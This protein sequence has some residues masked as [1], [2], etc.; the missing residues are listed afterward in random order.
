MNTHHQH[1]VE[2]QISKLRPTQMTVGRAEVEAK[3]REWQALGRKARERLL[4]LHWFP[5][6]MGP[7]G[8]FF[9]VDHHHL[10][11]ALQEESVRSGWVM[12][13]RDWSKLESKL[14]WRMMEFH[15]W[16]HP[17]DETGTRCSYARM[18]VHVEELRDDPYRSLAGL[19]RK[20]VALARRRQARYRPGWCGDSAGQ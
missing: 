18:P 11:V 1:L 3:R 6:V 9:I 20:A 12:V 2:V 19:V 8:R 15:Q 10:G 13:L 4:A 16:A 17:Y 5:A 14:F 7:K